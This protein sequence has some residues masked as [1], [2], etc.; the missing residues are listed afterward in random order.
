[1]D[2]REAILAVVTRLFPGPVASVAGGPPAT[3]TTGP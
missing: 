3:L 2:E 1:M